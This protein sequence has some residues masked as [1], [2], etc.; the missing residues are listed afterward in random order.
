[1]IGNLFFFP[2][3]LTCSLLNSTGK[4]LRLIS[5]LL[6]VCAPTFDT[7]A[8]FHLFDKGK[9]KESDFIELL[10]QSSLLQGTKASLI[11]S[12]KAK[13]KKTATGAQN[14]HTYLHFLKETKSKSNS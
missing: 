6:P 12:R 1:M 2:G 4:F 10:D 9:Q 3:K 11:K 8:S 5:F 7:V 13:K 14:I